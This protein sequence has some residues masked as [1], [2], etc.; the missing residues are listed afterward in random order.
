M[1]REIDF[2]LKICW[3][4]PFLSHMWEVVC[5]NTDMCKLNHCKKMKAEPNR[6]IPWKLI[7]SIE[8]LVVP[9][10]IFNELQLC[11]FMKSM[12]FLLIAHDSLNVCDQHLWA[13]WCCGFILQIELAAAAPLTPLTWLGYQMMV[14]K[15]M[16]ESQ[17]MLSFFYF[18]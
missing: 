5:L 1:L 16:I 13:L 9:R 11:K 15:W 18:S 3:E 7:E 2:L 10:V 8:L 4:I 6:L 17:V 14:S 12:L